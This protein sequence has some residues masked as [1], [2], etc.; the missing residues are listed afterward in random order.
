MIE[1][2]HYVRR[3][4][5]IPLC[6]LMPVPF[7]EISCVYDNSQTNVIL[8]KH[9][10][11]AYNMTMYITHI[12]STLTTVTSCCTTSLTLYTQTKTNDYVIITS[13]DIKSK[14]KLTSLQN[15]NCWHWHFGQNLPVR[16][17]KLIS[18]RFIGTLHCI[19]I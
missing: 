3:K 6:L 7:H 5:T 13:V 9:H 1:E 12:I 11:T 2:G 16:K 18:P 15:Y 14:C 19:D 8:Q 17:W 10:L 4:D